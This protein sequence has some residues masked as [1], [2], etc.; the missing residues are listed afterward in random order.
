VKPRMCAGFFAHLLIHRSSCCS[1]QTAR[2]WT[3]KLSHDIHA[4]MLVPVRQFIFRV[5]LPSVK[6]PAKPPKAKLIK[7][8]LMV[9]A[10]HRQKA[11]PLR[12]PSVRHMRGTLRI[13]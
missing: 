7:A 2:D 10:A 13:V 3:R 1:I 8:H 9:L 4:A 12:S 6:P 11:I 5:L